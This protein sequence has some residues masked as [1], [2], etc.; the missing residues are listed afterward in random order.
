MK[1][2]VITVL[3]LSLLSSM[4][5]SNLGVS[6]QTILNGLEDFFNLSSG[7]TTGKER[8]DIVN[9]EIFGDE[10]NPKRTSISFYCDE[11]TEL[12]PFLKEILLSWL[13]NVLHSSSADAF[14]WIINMIEINFDQTDYEFFKYYDKL[15]INIEKTKEN[16]LV[17][18]IEGK[19]SGNIIIEEQTH[20][21]YETPSGP[22]PSYL[23]EY[24]VWCA[25]DG[26]SKYMPS[27]Y[28]Y[29]FSNFSSYQ[30]EAE[31][32]ALLDA[33]MLGYLDQDFLPGSYQ[34]SPAYLTYDKNNYNDTAMIM[35]DW[36]GDDHNYIKTQNAPE[37]HKLVVEISP[38]NGGAVSFDNRNWSN[39]LTQTVDRKSVV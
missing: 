15:K 12:T 27:Y 20:P 29:P 3:F 14:N 10:N 28:Q 7:D 17:I 9:L 37:K 16:H 11:E 23:E 21:K 13:N 35:F 24:N 32:N 6:Q 39:K 33:L 25:N 36:S 2:F 5:F 31:Y 8:K 26:K 19:E 4:T 1:I 22:P 18:M 34:Y 38:P 30:E